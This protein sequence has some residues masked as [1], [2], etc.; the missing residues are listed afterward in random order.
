MSP[1]CP[2]RAQDGG[3]KRV[4]CPRIQPLASL[5]DPTH[6]LNRPKHLF[7]VVS[8]VSRRSAGIGVEGRRVGEDLVDARSPENASRLL[9]AFIVPLAA[10]RMPDTSARADDDARERP[11]RLADGAWYAHR[12]PQP[13]GG[14]RAL[15]SGCRRFEGDLR[16]HHRRSKRFRERSR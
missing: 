15:P 2:I 10:Y 11:M 4:M 9:Q 3:T 5:S 8:G 13:C 7:L 12:P 14:D 16:L 6:A 1:D